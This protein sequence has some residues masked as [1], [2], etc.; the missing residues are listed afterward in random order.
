[1]TD[2]SSSKIARVMSRVL[3]CPPRSIV[4][5]LCLFSTSSENIIKAFKNIIKAFKKAV[6]YLWHSNIPAGRLLALIY[7]EGIRTL[8]CGSMTIKINNFYL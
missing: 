4:R 2:S 8:M 1:M 3:A 5:Q 6:T 7:S